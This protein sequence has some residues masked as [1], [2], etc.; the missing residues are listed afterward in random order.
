MNQ[1]IQMR[2]VWDKHTTACL[3]LMGKH[4]D[5]INTS[6]FCAHSPVQA[7]KGR[8]NH[9]IWAALSLFSLSDSPRVA[10]TGSRCKTGV[11]VS[12]A[13]C[14]ALSS[15]LSKIIHLIPVRTDTRGGAQPVAGQE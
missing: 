12:G 5:W 3:S 8:R 6:T 2:F 1:D 9:P 7:E 10:Q 4:T 11:L 13:E 14:S 15:R